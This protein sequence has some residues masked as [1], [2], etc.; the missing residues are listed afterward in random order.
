MFCRKAEVKWN[1]FRFRD[2]TQ[3][4]VWRSFMENWTNECT[5]L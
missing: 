1:T 2:N 5:R 4:V 3:C